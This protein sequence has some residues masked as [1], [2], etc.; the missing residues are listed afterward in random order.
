VR[1]EKEY[2]AHIPSPRVGKD[3]ISLAAHILES[4][5]TKFDPRQFKDQYDKALRKLVQRKA[6]VVPSRYL[7]TPRTIL[8][9]SPVAAEG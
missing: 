5:A 6:S 4:K 8:S 1:S 7:T 9:V 3:M 2:L